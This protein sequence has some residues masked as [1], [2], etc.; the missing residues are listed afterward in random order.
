MDELH[1]TVE[2]IDAYENAREE[3]NEEIRELKEQHIAPRRA[4]RTELGGKRRE[5][6]VDGLYQVQEALNDGESMPLLRVREITRGLDYAYTETLTEDGVIATDRK[7][8]SEYHDDDFGIENLYTW[9]HDMPHKHDRLEPPLDIA[10]EYLQGDGARS[11]YINK[12]A[13]RLEH[14][15]NGEDT[16]PSTGLDYV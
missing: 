3:L 12:L 1:E 8:L 10:D 9:P 6:I 15:A 13:E 11:R 4:E 16:L 7:C 5:A 2:Q 14:I